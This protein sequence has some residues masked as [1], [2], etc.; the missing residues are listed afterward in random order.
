M[1]TLYYFAEESQLLVIGAINKSELESGFLQ[2]MEMGSRHFPLGDLYKT[3]V[4]EMAKRLKLP[5]QIIET[6]P[7]IDFARDR[8][9]K[10]SLIIPYQRLDTILKFLDQGN[11]SAKEISFLTDVSFEIVKE[12]IKRKKNSPARTNPP[13]ICK[14]KN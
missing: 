13:I 5:Q 14:I 2:N 11:F 12:I 1:T 8:G 7:I 4:I 10:Q 6:I 3:E 9:K